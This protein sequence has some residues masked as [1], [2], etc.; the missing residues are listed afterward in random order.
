MTS[1]ITVAGDSPYDV[2]IGIGILAEFP[3]LL[4]AS[5][6]RVAVIHQPAVRAIAEAVASSV[7]SGVEAHLFQI[8]DAESAKT[9]AVAIAIWDFLGEHRFTRSAVVVGVGGGGGHRSGWIC[10]CDLA[11]RSAR[12][13]G[14]D[15]AARHGRRRGRGQDRHQHRGR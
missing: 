12:R 5:V 1:R 2:V 10:G 13:P 14:A 8:P 9:A 11:A 6:R 15:D 3:A 7:P 4:G